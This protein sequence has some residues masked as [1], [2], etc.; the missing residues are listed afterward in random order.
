[1]RRSVMTPVSWTEPFVSVQLTSDVLCAF[2][3]IYCGLNWSMYRR[4]RI[5][6][7]HVGNDKKDGKEGGKDD[8]KKGS[9]KDGT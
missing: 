4:A 7:Q 8:G 1:M 6:Q 3:A 5:A 2:T 9:K